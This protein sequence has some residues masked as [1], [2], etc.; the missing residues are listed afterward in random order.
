MHSQLDLA[1]F[2]PKVCCFDPSGVLGSNTKRGRVR[3]QN[4]QSDNAPESY[5]GENWLSGI[6]WELAHAI[7]EQR[8]RLLNNCLNVALSRR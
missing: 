4:T 7:A 1:Y 2:Q 8:V 3:R 5:L 6:N